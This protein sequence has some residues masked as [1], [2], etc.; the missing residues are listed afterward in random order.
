MATVKGDV[1]LNDFMTKNLRMMTQAVNM[2]VSELER[3]KKSVGKEVDVSGLN[4]IKERVAAVDIE[5]EKAVEEQ[6]KLSEKVKS[7]A[8]NYSNLGS[9]VKTVISAIGVKKIV[10]LSDQNTQISA[11]LKIMTGGTEEEVA[12]LKDKIFASAQR[13]R[14]DYFN[15]ADVVSKL[16]MRAGDAFNNT[17]EMIAFS[18]NLNKMFVIAGASQEEMSSASLQLTQAL[19]SGVLRGEELNAVFEA[20]PNIIQTIADYI[21]VPIGKIRDLASEGKITADIVKNAM[22]SATDDINKD[23]DEIPLTWGQVWTSICNRVIKVTEPLLEVISWLA[24]NWE[25]L[26]PIVLGV[27]AAVGT[28]VAI[29]TAYNIITGISAGVSALHAAGLMLQSGATLT[30]TVAQH[31][32]NA[33]LLACPLT[34]IVIAIVAL[35][36]V[37]VY[38]WNTN[39]KVAKGMLF[40]WDSFLIGLDVF[41]LGF[42]GTWYGLL[43]FLGYFK[44]GA[45]A[46][47]DGFINSA[48]LLINGF[49]EMLNLIP[50]V[51]INTISWRSTLATD[52]ATEFAKEKAERDAE[53]ADDAL[54]IYNRAQELEE[55]RDERVENRAKLDLP[56]GVDELFDG[57]FDIGNVANVENIEGEVDVASEDLKLLRELAEQ[58]YI[59]NYISNEPVVYVTTGDV[60]ENADI[61]TLIRGIGSVIREEIDSSMEGV[62]VG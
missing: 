3:M 11:R 59:Q 29:Q 6:E 48:V 57:G 10:G 40:I 33:A 49:I 24:Q 36:A 42:K 25:T 56:G 13:S 8:K 58:Q 41:A 38:L 15:T 18:E 39:D 47:I 54:A 28:Y 12:A 30:A 14:A 60:H 7:T 27:A 50:G 17:D 21:G 61:N 34:W 9:I 32:L 5:L 4:R 46:I 16:G 51:S 45:L 43:D 20:A 26:E 2:T 1:R 22:L 62:P 44:I 55:S 37:L 35:V 52:A 53:L 23:F 31:G 19:G